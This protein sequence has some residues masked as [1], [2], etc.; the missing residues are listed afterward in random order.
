MALSVV[1]KD[2]H[3]LNF[4]LAMKDTACI[5]DADAERALLNTEIRSEDDIATVVDYLKHYRPHLYK[6]YTDAIKATH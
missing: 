1:E 3:L 6:K 4:K 5:N 2:N